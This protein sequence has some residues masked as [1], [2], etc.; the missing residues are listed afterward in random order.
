MPWLAL[1]L[2][3]Q[4]FSITTFNIIYDTIYTSGKQYL[5]TSPPG[6]TIKLDPAEENVMVDLFDPT[7]SVKQ[8]S[9]GTNCI[10]ITTIT[11]TTTS[12]CTTANGVYCLGPGTSKKSLTCKQFFHLG[13]IINN[14]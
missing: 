11:I 14:V 2:D 1:K 12:D 6:T 8:I 13:I 10:D 7:D 9:D 4:Y 3:M 5:A